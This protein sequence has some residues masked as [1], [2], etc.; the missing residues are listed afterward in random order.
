[1]HTCIFRENIELIQGTSPFPLVLL[2]LRRRQ[3]ELDVQAFRSPATS[4]NFAEI[5]RRD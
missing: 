1:M 3:L 2:G 4:G 5:P